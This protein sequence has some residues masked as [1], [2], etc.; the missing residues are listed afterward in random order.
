[1]SAKTKRLIPFILLVCAIIVIYITDLHREL[2]FDRLRD[3]QARVTEYVHAHPFLAPLIFLGIYIASV[4]LIIPDSTILSF[5]AGMIFDVPA[6]LFYVVISETIGGVIFFAIFHGAF[7]QL[8]RK[9]EKPLLNKM[10]KE[11]RTHSASYLLFLRLSHIIPFWLTNVSAAYFKVPYW[12]FTWTCFVGVI[13]LNYI[14][15][16]AGHSVAKVF[17]ADKKITFSDV[18]TLQTKLALVALG[19]LALL[20]ILYKKYLRKK[21]WKL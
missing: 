13:P 15:V 3:E 14:L 21:R 18:F 11:F 1:M 7:G 5:L 12:T 16:E 2:S 8:M 17:A 20:P 9:R 4:I 19:L 10:R 6:A